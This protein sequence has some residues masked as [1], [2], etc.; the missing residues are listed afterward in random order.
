MTEQLKGRAELIAD[1]GR[2]A[3]SAEDFFRSPEY[4]GAEGATHTLTVTSAQMMV[5]APV[6]VREIEATGRLDAISPYG[7]PGAIVAGA[8]PA[9]G[10]ATIDPAEVD[11]S[12]TG[13]VSVFMR[14]R[15]GPAPPFDGSSERS[16]VQVADPGLERKSRMSDRQQI[17]KNLK[18]GY[19]LRV[20]PGPESSAADRAAFHAAYT[21]TMSRTGASPRYYF[22]AEYF[23]TVLATPATWLF[24][25]EEPG[26]QVAAASIAVASDGMLHYYLSGTADDHLRGAPM[27]NILA[28]MTDFAW[29]R[30]L[31]LNLG[32]GIEPGDR[33][34]EFKRGFANREETWRTSEIVCDAAAYAELSAG[35]DPAG[36]FPAYRAP[37]PPA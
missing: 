6:I 19:R 15:L 30:E 8:G 10:S 1:G 2:G 18:A 16:V 26:G 27:K 14:H 29:Q 23:D 32:G 24:L 9:T 7:Y 35:R 33:L 13:L 5:A 11:W 12:G 21:Q 22:T 17:R 20:E 36:F 25:I 37:L 28:E 4:L 3:A 31:P 34:E